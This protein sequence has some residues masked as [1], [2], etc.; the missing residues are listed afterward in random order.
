M[1][2]ISLFGQITSPQKVAKEGKTPYSRK[3]QDGDIL[4]S[5][6]W[7]ELYVGGCQNPVALGR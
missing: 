2:Y 1:N 3:N 4:L 6:N 7:P 5:C